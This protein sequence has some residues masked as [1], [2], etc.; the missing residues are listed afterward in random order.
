MCIHQLSS[1]WTQ[2][3]SC[4]QQCHWF[5]YQEID[6]VPRNNAPAKFKYT[7]STST[8]VALPITAS[9]HMLATL[10][11]LHPAASSLDFRIAE[12]PARYGQIQTSRPFGPLSHPIACTLMK[13]RCSDLHWSTLSSGPEYSAIAARASTQLSFQNSSCRFRTADCLNKL[14]GLALSRCSPH[15]TQRDSEAKLHLCH[16][17]FQRTNYSSA[18]FIPSKI[19]SMSL[20][21]SPLAALLRNVCMEKEAIL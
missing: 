17:Q 8:N 12:I 5:G 1:E 3:I 20:R 10:L 16:H 4:A 13:G 15:S 18:S 19:W 21:R 11:R 9:I 2:K 7:F 14:S 6:L